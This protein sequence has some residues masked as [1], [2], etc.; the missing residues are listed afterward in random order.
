MGH[1]TVFWTTI[2]AVKFTNYWH[3]TKSML[4]TNIIR[5]YKYEIK[6]SF[7][8]KLKIEWILI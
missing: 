7:L 1:R 4:Y 6:V 3:N 5:I 8:N 2:T